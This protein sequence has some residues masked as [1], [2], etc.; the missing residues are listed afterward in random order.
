M[1]TF[2]RRLV[3]SDY[4]KREQILAELREEA[5]GSFSV[6]QQALYEEAEACGS[7]EL[8]LENVKQRISHIM[9]R[10]DFS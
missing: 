3:A 2:L 7:T 10:S 5:C 6:V 4:E 9:E 8:R 1:F